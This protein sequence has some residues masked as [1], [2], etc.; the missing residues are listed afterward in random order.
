MVLLVRFVVFVSWVIVECR[1]LGQPVA[2]DT[3]FL[4]MC[5]KSKAPHSRLLCPAV[6]PGFD[7]GVTDTSV[8]QP[9]GVTA[10]QSHQP[11]AGVDLS[12]CGH[13]AAVT[14][15]RLLGLREGEVWRVYQEV[16][17]PYG[18]GGRYTKSWFVKVVYQRYLWKEIEIIEM[19]KRL[20]LGTHV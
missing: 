19:K 15:A 16:N 1:R 14:P 7:D 4:V 10:V 5:R 2:I 12:H 9:A 17:R 13:L 6:S 8:S 20:R 18:N 3:K 11:P